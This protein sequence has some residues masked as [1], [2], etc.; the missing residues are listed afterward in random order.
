MIV[1]EKERFRHEN[2]RI[3][4]SLRNMKRE[5][6]ASDVLNLFPKKLPAL[7]KLVLELRVL[8]LSFQLGV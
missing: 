6:L 3:S 1:W 2:E 7:C 5:D 8:V 4:E